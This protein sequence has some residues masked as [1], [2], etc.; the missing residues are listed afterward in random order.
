MS[1]LE[2]MVEPKAAEIRRIEVIS[3]GGR[4]RRFSQAEKAGIVEETLVPGVAVSEVARRH[5]LTPQQLF[6]WRRDARC[7][8]AKSEEEPA[9]V[10]AMIAAED[11]P[12]VAPAAQETARPASPIMEVEIGDSHVWVWRE[13][14][15]RLATAVIRAL[16]AGE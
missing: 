1:R 16:K 6:A 14:D 13:V 5:G 7:K 3:G 4:R 10:P 8:S 9:F 12:N 11:A 15:I 2:L